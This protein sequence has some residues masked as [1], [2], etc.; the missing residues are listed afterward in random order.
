MALV[1]TS[2][3]KPETDGV[4]QLL[5]F[6]FDIESWESILPGSYDG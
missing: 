2:T 6:P 5:L 4:A 3:Q 1:F